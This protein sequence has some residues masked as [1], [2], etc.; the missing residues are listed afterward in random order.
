MADGVVPY[1]AYERHFSSRGVDTRKEE[2]R[3]KTGTTIW[4][5]FND[6][7]RFA[8]HTPLLAADDVRRNSVGDM[9]FGL[10]AAKHDITNNVKYEP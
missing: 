9:A 3:I 2:A 10:L 5:L 8:T 7:T 6:L 4:Q 1:A